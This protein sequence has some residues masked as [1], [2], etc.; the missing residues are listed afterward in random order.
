[1]VDVAFDYLSSNKKPL[2]NRTQVRFHTGTSEILGILVLLDAE[3]LN[4]GVSTVAQI[5]LESPVTLVK[6]DRFV[7]RSY[8]PVRTIGG[9]Q[10]LNPIPGK[11]KRFKP[12]VVEGLKGLLS[13]DPEEIV[14][15]HLQASGYKGASFSDLKL[16]V[17]LSDKP[18]EQLLKALMSNR[19]VLQTDK[20]NRIFIH[21]DTAERL[22][23]EMID[24]LDRYHRQFPLKQGMLKEELKSKFP[25]TA[26]GK[27]FTLM[28][29]QQTK[30]GKVVAEEKMVRLATHKVSLAVD[31]TELKDKILKTYAQSGLQP[32]YFKELV[33]NMGVNAQVA[34]D[35]LMLLVDEGRIVKVKEELYFD[36]A[37]METLKQRLVDFLDA[38]GEIST[39]QFKEMT[40]ASRKYV[41]P[42]IEHFDAGNVTIRIGDI[43]KL[44]KR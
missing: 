17:N 13:D 25:K 19:S 38:N 30:E 34:K 2:K 31:Q 24:H 35:V 12:E 10:I 27:L 9:G 23:Q 37:A 22:K 1:M 6:D 20:E 16:M 40:G 14:A 39:P 28:L 5:R 8:S 4:P 3:E 41:I 36:S 42:I 44:R 21:A 26:S 15:Y 11:H 18:L 7:V 43:R 33:G 32:P 29:N